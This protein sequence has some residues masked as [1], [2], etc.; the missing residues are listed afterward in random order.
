MPT[1]KK[2]DKTLFLTL[3][4]HRGEGSI[5]IASVGYY[6]KVGQSNHYLLSAPGWPLLSRRHAMTRSAF[7]SSFFPSRPGGYWTTP[8]IPGRPDQ[9]LLA[10]PYCSQAPQPILIR[11]H[12]RTFHSCEA[13]S[14]ECLEPTE[15][16]CPSML[17]HPNHIS[18]KISKHSP[19]MI[20]FSNRY[21]FLFLYIPIVGNDSFCMNVTLIFFT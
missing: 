3:S 13:G 19:R 5:W 18:P 21:L 16:R 17:P 4:K 8:E 20:S 15:G 10:E 12:S 2:E 7:P 9:P 1:D 6:A 11:A 14:P